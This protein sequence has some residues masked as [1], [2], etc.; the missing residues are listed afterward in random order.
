MECLKNN[1]VRGQLLDGRFRTVAPLNHG[2]FGMVFLATDTKTGQDVAIKCLTKV[3]S[4][5][6]SAP[7]AIDDRFEELDCHKRLAY[8]PNIVNLIHSFETE[9]HLYLV[10]EYC[11]NG[12]LY[13]AIRL[14]RGPL[15][16]EHVRDFM[17]QLVSAV[18]HVH[19]NGMYHRDIKPENIFLTQ[20]GSMKLGD[21]GLAT[22]DAW[23]HEGCV[24]SDRYMAPEQYEP[25][26]NGYSPAKADIWA[27]G[28][29][30]LNILFA[31]NP[32]ATPTESDVLF[33]DYV[34]DRQSLFDI[35]TNMSQD[36][37]EILRFAL[38]IDPEKRSLSAVRD[39]ITRA[40]CFTTD[41]E[42]LDEFC[43]DDRE[44][45]PASAN[46]EPLRTPSI[47]TT[48]ANQGDSFPWAKALQSS[49]P[50]AFRQLS[51]IPDNES[52]SE[53]LF[54]PSETA[55]TSWFSIHQGTL[56]MASVLESALGESFKSTNFRR[57]AP[58]YPPPSDP[59]PI[60]GSLPGHATKP[61]PSLS[62]VFGR[63]KNEQI[64]K[65]WSDL[66]DEEE[67]SE[68]EDIAL[69][70][71]REQNSR[72]WSHE[73]S[74]IDVPT[75]V[76]GLREPHSSSLLNV[77][78]AVPEAPVTK[79]VDISAKSPPV[80][81]AHVDF[82]SVPRYMPS[83]PKKSNLDKWA[84]LGDKRRNYKPTERSFGQPKSANNMAWRKD[85]GLGSSGFDYGTWAKKDNLAHQDRRRRPF[86][87]KGK[88][89][90]AM[91]SPKA[92]NPH[93]LSEYDGSIDEDLDLVGGW[94]DLHL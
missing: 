44:V 46:R 43:T 54:P 50:P 94:H 85:W 67:E 78:S 15:E 38:A 11:A 48:F 8:H 93:I 29:C 22:S 63:N 77:R 3:P 35:F 30:L 89:R 45:V 25:G 1:F 86:L 68:H 42:V 17:L 91:E 49:P 69:H 9:A 70:Q 5:D 83:P 12:D 59:V 81:V 27:V 13:E 66:W 40:V 37:F 16:T 75:P 41:D 64:S 39:A 32:F 47:Q 88:R 82:G 76:G 18:E 52:Y 87:E 26:A 33:A 31:R 73:S 23:C 79:P 2:S 4:D 84:A 20:D 10:L 24:G 55:G 62:M 80:D 34:R 72:S 57:N 92:V 65:S 60:T 53:D 58:R 71:R 6:P 21:F 14:N 28:I 7:P 74:G 90:D 61:L 51:A 36:T 19:A 56:S